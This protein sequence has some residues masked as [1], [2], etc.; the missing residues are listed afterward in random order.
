LRKALAIYR[1]AVEYFRQD[2]FAIA[3][4]LAL[5]GISILL[6]VL[7]PIPLT[8][9]IDT[10]IKQEG[11]GAGTGFWAS[12]LWTHYTRGLDKT[13]QVIILAAIMFVIRM[14]AELLRFWQ[15]LLTIRVGY[16]G[17]LRVRTDLFGKLQSLSLGYHKSRPQGDV[18]YRLSSDTN[19]FQGIL[20]IVL[21]VLI[22]V[23]TLVAMAWVMFSMNWRLTLISLLVLPLLLLNMKLYGKKLK[24]LYIDSYE[25]DSKIT[26]AIQR[27]MASIGLVQAFGRERDEYNNFS[28]T[29]GSS[30]RIKMRLHWHEVMYWLVLGA[31]FAVGATVILGYGGYLAVNSAT[32]GFSVGMLTAFLMYLDKLYDPLNKLTGSGASLAGSQAQV[33]R[34]FETLDHD[35]VVKDEP[36]AIHLTQQPRT[37]TLE[38]VTFGYNP[39][40]PILKDV[41]VTIKP[42]SMVAFVGSSG[43]GK[44]TL[45]SLLPRFYDPQSGVMRLDGHD[46][47]TIKVADVRKHVALV[48]QE[49]TVLPASVSENI[50]Y[51]R[52]DASQ[53]D[54]QKA[55][56]LAGASGFIDKLDQKFDTLISESGANLSG[57][58]RQRISIARALLTNAPFVV[59]DE[60]TSALD[61]MHEALITQTLKGIKGL[62]T[63]VL[64][65]HRL[66]TVMDCDEIFVMHE[67]RIVEKG[68]HEQLVAQRGHYFE[69][70]K[71]QL[72]LTD[73]QMTQI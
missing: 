39:E 62:R 29:L 23:L 49:N 34:V 21:G 43:V 71:H 58:Q 44:T 36:G 6:S 1:R 57:G 32:T 18:I 13:Q 31:I 37:L 41:S 25:I 59:L 9:L 7:F 14:A 46:V 56:E 63:I 65:S 55:A 15:T 33:E 50:A 8:L 38:G 11:T 64:V 40:T 61:P 20:N 45:L 47:R 70:A 53:A 10:V 42:G 22:N 17:S 67:G 12:R 73:P 3:L 54:I 52:P 24:S 35:P 28:S 51:G 60:P 26:T 66:S 69:M 68:N 27:S 48:L 30:M 2:L 4:S 72:R 16:N 5:V 19:G